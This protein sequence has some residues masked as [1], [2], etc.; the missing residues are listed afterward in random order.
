MTQQT[1]GN[2]EI[3]GWILLASLVYFV[4]FLRSRRTGR[5]T[6]DDAPP[7][8]HSSADREEPHARS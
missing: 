3:T 2:L 4:A 5:W 7:D 6:L 1:R 8:D